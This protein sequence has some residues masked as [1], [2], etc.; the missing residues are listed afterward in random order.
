[1]AYGLTP[2]GFNPKPLQVIK[3]EIQASLNTAFGQ[4]L[5]FQPTTVLG[6]IVGIWSERENTQWQQQEAIYASQYP[7][8]AEG[9]SVDNILALNNLRRLGATPSKTAPTSSTGTPGLVVTGTP[10]TVVTA[11][12][13]ISIPGQPSVQ[14]SIDT[15]V[16]IAAAVNAIQTRRT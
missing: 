14:F 9:T 1:M 7:Q 13:L 4:N 10:G 6:Q 3:A 11:G 2:Q 12:S 8:G 16:T 5:D 15:T